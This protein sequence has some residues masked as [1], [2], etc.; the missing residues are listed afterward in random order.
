MKKLFLLI[1]TLLC[2][3]GEAQL[4]GDTFTE[5]KKKGQA[6]VVFAYVE[7]PGYTYT[8]SDGKLSGIGIDLMNGFKKYM[9]VNE[10]VKM[11]V[12]YKNDANDFNLFLNE[13][14]TS[15]GGVF[16]IGNIAITEERKKDLKF[17]P[18]Y[19]TVFTLMITHKDAPSLQKMELI[20]NTFKGYKAY[21]TKATIWEKNVIDIKK[22]YFPELEIV[23][24]PSINELVDRVANDPKSFTIVSINYYSVGLKNNKPIKRHPAGDSKPLQVG[25]IMPKNSDWDNVLTQYLQSG[26]LEGSEF[27]KSISTHLG[28]NALKLLDAVKQ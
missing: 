27:R 1:L 14:K 24:V 2:F 13:V 6:N 23:Y 21:V 19:L 9:E 28:V 3:R 16:G 25:I 17:S 12:T 8:A 4:K 7:T 15:N 11:N 18:N 10:K 22:N 26:V 5:A 20:S